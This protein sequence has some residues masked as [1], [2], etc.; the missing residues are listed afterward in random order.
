MDY[1]QV[2]R[3]DSVIQ[4]EAVFESITYKKGCLSANYG[5]ISICFTSKGLKRLNILHKLYRLFNGAFYLHLCSL[6]ASVHY[7]HLS[8][9]CSI[10]PI[11]STVFNTIAWQCSQNIRLVPA[12]ASLFGCDSFRLVIFCCLGWQEEVSRYQDKQTY[13]EQRAQAKRETMKA[14]AWR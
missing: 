10:Q 5:F 9:S 3:I 13:R 4:L 6:K 8:D 14:S 7:E 12:S 11:H 2:K 1:F